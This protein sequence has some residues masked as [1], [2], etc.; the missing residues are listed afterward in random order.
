MYTSVVSHWKRNPSFQVL[1]WQV[2][3]SCPAQLIYNC[4]MLVTEYLSLNIAHKDSTS[5]PNLF[6]EFYFIC[7]YMHVCGCTKMWMHMKT[8]DNPSCHFYFY[9]VFCF[10]FV[11]LWSR[12]FPCSGTPQVVW[13]CCQEFSGNCLF[14]PHQCWD[15]NCRPQHLAIL[16]A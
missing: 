6:W 14:S 5:V 9:F 16:H 15:Y 4:V 13:T 7:I 3:A 1:G 11:F 2:H 8:R 10:L 12:T